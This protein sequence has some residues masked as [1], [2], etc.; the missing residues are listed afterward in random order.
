M[1]PTKFLNVCLSMDLCVFFS[2]NHFFVLT[3]FR[4]LCIFIV[5]SVVLFVGCALCFGCCLVEILRCTIIAGFERCH[6]QC[7][8]YTRCGYMVYAM[9]AHNVKSMCN[10]MHE[11]SMEKKNRSFVNLTKKKRGNFFA[12]CE[13]EV[14]ARKI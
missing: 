7:V 13:A 10:S 5:F 11:K 6:S 9:R 3:F 2:K 12:F 1:Y 4:L 8:A 14:N